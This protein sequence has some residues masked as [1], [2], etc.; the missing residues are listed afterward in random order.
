[1]AKKMFKQ[2]H[3]KSKGEKLDIDSILSKEG[4]ESLSDG[5]VDFW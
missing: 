1:M 5:M 3:L 2:Q 4:I